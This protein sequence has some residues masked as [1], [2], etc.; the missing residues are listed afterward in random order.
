MRRICFA[1]HVSDDAPT[2]ATSFANFVHGDAKAVARRHS[3]ADHRRAVCADDHAVIGPPR[4]GEIECS[5]ADVRF[6]LGRTTEMRKA[7]RL[8]V[9]GPPSNKN[10]QATSGPA[11]LVQRGVYVDHQAFPQTAFLPYSGGISR[12][13]PGSAG[14]PNT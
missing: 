1:A 11:M 14:E 5:G 3:A 12:R 9:D 7:E 13:R 6:Q 8:R 4:G 10:G 2:P